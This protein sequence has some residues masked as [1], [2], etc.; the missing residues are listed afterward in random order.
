MCAEETGECWGAGEGKRVLGRLGTSGR[1]S[2]AMETEAEVLGWSRRTYGW[3][4]NGA[5][6]GGDQY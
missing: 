2:G 6:G 5:A 3:V 4:L 1:L